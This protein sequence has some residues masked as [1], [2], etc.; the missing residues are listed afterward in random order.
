MPYNI[1]GMTNFEKEMCKW[2]NG[3]ERSFVNAMISLPMVYCTLVKN[4]RHAGR[5][6]GAIHRAR[7]R[8]Q[9]KKAPK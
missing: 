9:K 8:Q 2:K 1:N 3:H 7:H 5:Y 6:F 4:S